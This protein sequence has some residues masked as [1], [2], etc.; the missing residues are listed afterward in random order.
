[1]VSWRRQGP[2]TRLAVAVAADEGLAP[3]GPPDREGGD[4]AAVG[5]EARGDADPPGVDAAAEAGRSAA[6]EGGATSTHRRSGGRSDGR[7]VGGGGARRGPATRSR[8]G[9]RRTDAAALGRLR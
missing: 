6:R 9:R 5:A 7:R 4:D 1:M 8:L 3:Q 2:R